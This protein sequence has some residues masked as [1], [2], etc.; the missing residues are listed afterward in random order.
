MEMKKN[1][2]VIETKS[3]IARR[4]NRNEMDTHPEKVN[5]TISR[6]LGPG[7]D[8]RSTVGSNLMMHGGQKEAHSSDI[9]PSRH[10]LICV[11]EFPKCN[12]MSETETFSGPRPL[13]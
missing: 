8:R 1:S 10:Y 7:A 6:P 4:E 2:T 5:Q 11:A 13:P 3:P 9:T 12:V